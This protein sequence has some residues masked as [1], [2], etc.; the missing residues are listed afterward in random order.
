MTS[1]ILVITITR[2]TD[3]KRTVMNLVQCIRESKGVTQSELAKAIGVSQA[4][5]SQLESGKRN[6]GIKALA[7][8]FTIAD[9]EQREMIEEAIICRF[10]PGCSGER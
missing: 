2:V 1:V 10:S 4:Y 9:E 6:P 7:G 5:I 8:L 3:T